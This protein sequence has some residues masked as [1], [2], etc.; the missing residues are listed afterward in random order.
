MEHFIQSII[1]PIDTNDINYINLLWKNNKIE[2][3]WEF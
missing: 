2:I 3:Q 1:C